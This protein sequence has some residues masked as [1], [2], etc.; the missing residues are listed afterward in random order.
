MWENII[1]CHDCFGKLVIDGG[2]KNL[3]VAETLAARY[4]IKYI[5]ISAYH[6]QANRMIEQSHKPIMDALS[7]MLGK[8][9]ENLYAVLWADQSTHN[10]TDI[11]FF[12]MVC[13]SKSV[14]PI[15]LDIL[16]WQIFSW[17][18]IHL[19]ADLIE[20][21]ARQLQKK[22]ENMEKITLLLQ[23]MRMQGKNLFNDFYR[24]C[25]KLL[26]IDDLVLFYDLQREANILIKLAFKWLGLYCIAEVI[27]EKSTY[28]LKKLNGTQLRSTIAGN[29]LK[30]F[31]LCQQLDE[32]ED[33]TDPELKDNDDS[34]NSM[35]KIS[36]L[37]V[38]IS[39]FS[40]VS[41][42][43]LSHFLFIKL[44]YTFLKQD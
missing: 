25:E 35:M 8:W 11:I 3:E 10:P 31:H 26:A 6:F 20:I 9:V 42:F 16:T 21:R 29:R 13:G 24:I 38:E 5:V 19:T 41:D 30:R 15:E 34:D 37:V 43:F 23:K 28:F 27:P 44:G 2:Q 12:C 33:L 36:L 40:F 7:K 4:S 39:S 22:N 17:D 18:Q 1:C 32:F 14:L